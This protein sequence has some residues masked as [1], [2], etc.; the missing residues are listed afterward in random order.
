MRT[1]R[2]IL[3]ERT[4][5]AVDVGDLELREKEPVGPPLARAAR[6]VAVAHP[7]QVLLSSAAHDALALDGRSGWA[8]ESLGQ[9][10]IVGLDP[11]VYVYQLVGR[12]FGGDFPPLRV[13]RLPPP[14]PGSVERSVPGYELRHLIGIAQLGEVHRA[15]QSSVGRE[16]ALRIFGRGMVIAH[17]AGSKA[18]AFSSSGMIA[19]GSSADG[20]KVWSPDGELVASVPTHQDDDPTFA[21]APGTD[22]LFYEDGNG[23]VRRFAVNVDDVTR[24]AHISPHPRLHPPGV[25]PVLPRPTVP[26]RSTSELRWAP[27]DSA[28]PT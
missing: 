2:S 23:V 28:A 17:A 1:A 7:G 4:R 16:V 22:T 25:R 21:F 20:L 12:G 27:V 15:Y 18:V 19:T 13:D 10:D 24:L 11:G 8:A 26:G 14:M 3:N 6:L 9:F 5:V